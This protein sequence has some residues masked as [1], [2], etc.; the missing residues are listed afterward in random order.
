MRRIEK[1]V[2]LIDSW[3]RVTENGVLVVKK[4]EESDGMSEHLYDI[5]AE[6]GRHCSSSFYKPLAEFWTM[7]GGMFLTATYNGIHRV[8]KVE[9]S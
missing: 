1:G 8:G 7:S 2:V 5:S 3:A 6:Q 9:G 4:R